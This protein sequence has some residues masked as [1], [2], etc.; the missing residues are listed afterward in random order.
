MLYDYVYVP[1]S[2]VQSTIVYLV[3][4]KSGNATETSDYGAGTI[5]LSNACTKILESVMINTV[6]Q[7]DAN[8]YQFGF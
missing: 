6:S 5:T 8:K 7:H 3:N 4:C 1:D 2:F